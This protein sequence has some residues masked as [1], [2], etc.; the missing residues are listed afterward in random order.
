M[1]KVLF[2][3]VVL[4]TALAVIVFAVN[5]RQAV[6]ID[7]WPLPYMIEMPIFA[8]ALIGVFVGFLWGGFVAWVGAGK[9][10]RRARELMRRVESDQRDMAIL[11]HK[12]ERLEA[13]EKRAAIPP[14]PADAA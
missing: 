3:I 13:A 14:P 4:P 9:T 1:A 10:R 2:W 12:I 6:E 7:T 8:V 11:K 5:N